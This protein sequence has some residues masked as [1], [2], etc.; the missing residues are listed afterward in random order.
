M[1]PITEEQFKAAL[2]VTVKKLVNPQIIDDI[3]DMLMNPEALE[4]FRENLLSY[5]NVMTEGRFKMTS[6]ISAVKYVSFKLLGHTNKDAYIKTFPDKY[7]GFLADG[8]AQ[9]DIASYTTAYNKSKLVNLIFEQT[10]VPFHVLNAPAYQDALN[11]QVDLMHHAK[12][13]KVRSDAANSV[14]VHLK[15]PESSKLELDITVKQDD[16]IRTLRETTLK[17]AKQQQE[18]ILNGSHSVKTIAEST[19]VNDD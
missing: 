16:S 10:L 17:L 12:S 5:T 1:D 9:K 18:L 8:V 11:T 14:M 4:H 3:N 6:Y 15:P 19:L 7:V 13:E 2:P